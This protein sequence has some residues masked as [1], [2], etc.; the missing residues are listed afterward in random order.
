[1]HALLQLLAQRAILRGVPQLCMACGTLQPETFHTNVTDYETSL[2]K[3]HLVAL[4]NR[5]LDPKAFRR[6]AKDAGDPERVH[7]LHSDFYNKRG[8]A[9][10]P[11]GELPYVS[12]ELDMG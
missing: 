12:P 1:M 5:D 10:Q 4:I 2:C 11:G 6:L 9:L 3:E 8:R 7:L